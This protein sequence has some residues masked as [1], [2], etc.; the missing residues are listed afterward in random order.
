[1]AGILGA[2]VLILITAYYMAIRP[3]PLV[4]GLRATYSWINAQVMSNSQAR[5][6]A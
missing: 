5:K 4:N 6:T 2:L 1:M 3:E